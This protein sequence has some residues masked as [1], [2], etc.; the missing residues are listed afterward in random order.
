[1]EGYYFW[2]LTLYFCYRPKQTI[3]EAEGEAAKSKKQVNFLPFMLAAILLTRTWRTS[4][5]CYNMW[6]L[7]IAACF[8]LS[9]A[10]IVFHII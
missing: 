6:S 2:S 1:M 10:I 8:Y 4:N 7:L 5:S 3:L 9:A